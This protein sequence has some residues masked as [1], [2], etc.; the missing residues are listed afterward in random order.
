MSSPYHHDGIMSRTVKG[1][2][3]RSNPNIRIFDVESGICRTVHLHRFVE[4]N[5]WFSLEYSNIW[6]IGGAKKVKRWYREIRTN[7]NAF[8]RESTRFRESIF[9]IN[10]LCLT[11]RPIK[12]RIT[13]EI[14]YKGLSYRPC[15]YIH[16]STIANVLDNA[17]QEEAA[18]NQV[19]K[20]KFKSH[21]TLFV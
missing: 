15:P 12:A 8:L 9:E 2:L 4:S 1:I 6:Q 19:D 10:F 14:Q 21:G 20:P 13:S 16:T 18:H 11:R 5:P 3:T 7:K 17:T